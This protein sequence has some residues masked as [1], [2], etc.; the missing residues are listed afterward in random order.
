[1]RVTYKE[2]AYPEW[3]EE[4]L[5]V[6]EII[7]TVARLLKQRVATHAPSAGLQQ[8]GS[9]EVDDGDAEALL[10]ELEF[11]AQLVESSEFWKGVIVGMLQAMPKP[12]PGI[13]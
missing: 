7:R 5:E 13:N 10:G 4:Y 12:A 11:V 8:D 9:Y 3:V 6:G 1:M 2:M